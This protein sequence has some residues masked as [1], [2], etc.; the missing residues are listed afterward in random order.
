MLIKNKAVFN[1]LNV[2]SLATAL[3]P[4]PFT[5]NGPNNSQKSYK[6]GDV[7]NDW[8]RQ[9]VQKIYQSP[10]L[11]LVYRAVSLLLFFFCLSNTKL[12]LLRLVFID[13]IMSLVK[14]N[15]AL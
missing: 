2:R 1:R 7:R 14:S 12:K 13:F 10:L 15:F 8:N 3:Q 11:E 4:H 6:D 5:P 9:E